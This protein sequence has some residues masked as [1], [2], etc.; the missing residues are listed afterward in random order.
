MVGQPR[1]AYDLLG[2]SPKASTAEITSAYRRLLRR[3]HPDSRDVSVAGD[4]VDDGLGA[5]AASALRII[6]GAYEVFRDPR[7]RA[8]YDRRQEASTPTT[9]SLRGGADK[10]FILR[11]GPVRWN[12]ERASTSVWHLNRQ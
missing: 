3:Y 9:S 6:I 12:D 2:V 11:A 8:D 7:S 4:T 1:T 10:G 5:D